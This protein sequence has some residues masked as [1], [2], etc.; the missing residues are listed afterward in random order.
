MSERVER[1]LLE[2]LGNP[3]TSP[4]GNPIPGLSELGAPPA[5]RVDPGEMSITEWI[6]GAAGETRASIRRLAEP[7]QA[8]PELLAQFAAAGVIPG[9]TASFTRLGDFV[10]IEVEGN[11]EAIDIPIEVAAHIFVS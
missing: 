8:E 10:R 5:P 4:Y 11:R 1:K 9:N 3:T 7:A 6:A 2:M